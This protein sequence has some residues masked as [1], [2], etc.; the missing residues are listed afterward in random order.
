MHKALRS[1]WFFALLFGGCTCSSDTHD[2]GKGD[3]PSFP[4]HNSRLTS[5]S[6]DHVHPSPL[7][8]EAPRRSPSGN[9]KPHKFSELSRVTKVVVSNHSREVL[10]I[11]SGPEIKEIIQFVNNHSEGW[12]IPWYGVPVPKWTVTIYSDDECLG[13]FGAGKG[14]FETQR[15]GGFFSKP[16]SE[17]QLRDFYRLI[18]AENEESPKSDSQP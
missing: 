9:Q 6:Q 18:H 13:S 14:F 15:D 12:E 8:Q 4:L 3:G 17:S 2:D 1:I 7:Q 10:K 16:A 11:E 5:G